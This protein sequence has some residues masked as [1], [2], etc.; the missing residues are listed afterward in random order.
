MTLKIAISSGKSD[1]GK[2]FILNNIFDYSIDLKKYLTFK[3][4]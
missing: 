3:D 4:K 1:T 2:T